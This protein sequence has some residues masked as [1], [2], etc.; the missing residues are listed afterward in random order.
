MDNNKLQ[1]NISKIGHLPRDYKKNNEDFY[2]N[3]KDK[4][5]HSF[6][7]DKNLN[8]KNVNKDSLNVEKSLTNKQKKIINKKTSEFTDLFFESDKIVKS[9]K[10][11]NIVMIVSMVIVECITLC[12]IFV[13]GTIIRYSN[14]TQKVS[15]NK[16]EIKNTSIEQST[17][18]V[19]K[20]YKTVAV[21]GLDSRSGN[22]S[23]GSNADVN[24]IINLNLETG[25]VKI[26][27]VYRDTF[28]NISDNNNYGKLNS[29]YSHGGPERAVKTLNKN[30]DLDIQNYFAFNWKAVADFVDGLGGVDIYVTPSEF[31]YMNAFIHEYCIETGIGKQNPA[32]YYIATAGYQTLNGVQALSYCRLR[33][34]DND[35]K[36]RERQVAVIKQC[37]EKA[38]NID[39]SKINELV[40]TVLPQISYEFDMNELLSIAKTIKGIHIEE[41]Y[42]LPEINYMLMMNMGSH[43]NCVVPNSLVRAAKQMHLDLF[44]DSDYKPSSIVNTCSNTI[45]ELKN[46]YQSES[47]ESETETIVD[48]GVPIPITNMDSNSVP[49]VSNSNNNSNIPSNDNM[50][51][52]NNKNLNGNSN[53]NNTNSNSNA[54]SNNNTNSNSNGNS[55]NNTTNNTNNNTPNNSNNSINNGTNNGVV[56]SDSP[57]FN[58]NM[59]LP[60]TDN[61]SNNTTNSNRIPNT[62]QNSTT[63]NN[64]SNSITQNNQT[65]ISPN[66]PTGFNNNNSTSN[67]P[68][69]N[70]SNNNISPGPNYTNNNITPGS[71]YTNN[72]ISP[73]FN[74]SNNGITPGYRYY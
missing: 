25:G 64:Y 47:E 10:K 62:N 28:L 59:P 37:I 48:N 2:N 18:E 29:A 36:R 54:N 20:G 14:S 72:N 11:T 16:S 70:Y 19:M 42:G 46:K 68:G 65:Q 40:E 43:G 8:K 32:A 53:V 12:V 58:N 15:F 9:K 3:Q 39:L 57:S 24:M 51:N 4:K 30:F 6:L 50:N 34:M 17:L 38:K 73:G 1:S 41:T 33:L 44:D 56:I 69:S 22:M 21:F 45:L 66:G 61:N 23:R 63:N 5:S 35:F 55:N 60:I 31:L 52:T 13:F 7:D 74:Y 67:Y 27:S 26:V 49:N 71:N